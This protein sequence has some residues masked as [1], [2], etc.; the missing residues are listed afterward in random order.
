MIKRFLSLM[1]VWSLLSTMLVGFI[2]LPASAQGVR[3]GIY[4]CNLPP[5]EYG[6]IRAIGYSREQYQLFRPMALAIWNMKG[7]ETH[8]SRF[9]WD[10]YFSAQLTAV[11]VNGITL[12]YSV[13]VSTIRHNPYELY[14]FVHRIDDF[15]VIYDDPCSTFVIDRNYFENILTALRA[16]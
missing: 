7:L 14:V 9:E 8:Y 5:P 13:N 11:G 6:M 16:D 3:G 15:G 12:S 1:F 2:L 10:H 4:S